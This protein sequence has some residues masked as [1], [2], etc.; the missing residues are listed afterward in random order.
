VCQSTII[1][2]LQKRKERF[3]IVTA[4]DKAAEKAAILEAR[5]KKFSTTTTAAI[6]EEEAE[7]LAKRAKRFN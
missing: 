4:E 1:L 7:K 3:S 5:K 2:S 6:S